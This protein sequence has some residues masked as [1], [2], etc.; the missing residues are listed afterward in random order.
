MTHFLPPP[1]LH[2]AHRVLLLSA[3]TAGRMPRVPLQGCLALATTISSSMSSGPSKDPPTP[4][5]VFPS[6]VMWLPGLSE[7]KSFVLWERP[8]QA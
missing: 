1:C 5:H 7:G 6:P 8:C 2:L 3:F 4:F